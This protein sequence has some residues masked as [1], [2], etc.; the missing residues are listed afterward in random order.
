MEHC[1]HICSW[2][3]DGERYRVWVRNRPT[4]CAEHA[5]FEEA[6]IALAD[7]ICLAFGDG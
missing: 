6:D 3:H 4:V 7:A 1:V 5:S 2:S